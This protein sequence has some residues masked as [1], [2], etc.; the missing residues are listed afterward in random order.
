MLSPAPMQSHQIRTRIAAALAVAEHARE[1]GE[2]RH[3]AMEHLASESRALRLS[4]FEAA[5]DAD[6]ITVRQEW[7]PSLNA[8]TTAY[9]E[10]DT[11]DR[12]VP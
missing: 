8:L 3:E 7:E 12:L 9:Y 4:I 2:S 10:L 5:A 1:T 6:I 11:R